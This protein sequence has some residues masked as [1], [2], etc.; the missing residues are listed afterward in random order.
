MRRDGDG[1]SKG[2]GFVNFE[3]HEDAKNAV[4]QCQGTNLNGKPI[5]CGRAQKK[6]ERQAELQKK[7][8]QIKME[9]FTRFQ[10]INLYI[11][12]LED[13]IDEERLKKEFSAFGVIR[14]AKIMDDGK[15]N[16]KGFGFICFTTA[17]EAQHAINEMNSRILQGCSK[18]LYVALHEPKDIRR[19]KLAQRHAHRTKQHLR[20]SVSNVPVGPGPVFS[21]APP[22]YYPTPP[23]SGTAPFVYQQPPQPPSMVPRQPTRGPWP[24]PQHQAQQY[25]LQNAG[26]PQYVTRPAR[27]RSGQMGGA[28]GGRVN[29][30][31]RNNQ[32]GAPQEVG[33]PQ[34]ISL[35]QLDQYPHDQ[36]KLLL[37]ERLYPLIQKSQAQ[38]AGKITGMLLDSG[39]SIEELFS[40]LN[41]EDK[42]NQKIEEAVN[43]LKRAQQ[44]EIPLEGT[45]EY[46]DQT[47]DLHDQE[48]H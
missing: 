40:L 7:F 5:W 29:Q 46:Q 42:L 35:V 17:E 27:G 23:P 34:E 20:P 3:N 37:G 2:F 13:E 48:V 9:Q 4:E 30:N 16:S 18:P 47:G 32:Q 1:V 28:R 11:K 8:K 15:G 45:D 19:Q 44:Q 38:L 24:A 31:R 39:W 25:P 10:G 33:I 26:S 21:A 14:S 22:V 43:V 12:N 41:D 6:A 36:Q